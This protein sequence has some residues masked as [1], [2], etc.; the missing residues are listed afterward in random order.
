M[1]AR[2][3]LLT[4][5]LAA[6]RKHALA[7]HA[8][9][10]RSS[11]N[12]ILLPLPA[13]RVAGMSLLVQVA[14][15]RGRVLIRGHQ[16]AAN[17]RSLSLLEHGRPHSLLR[18]LPR[19]RSVDHL[20]LLQQNVVHAGRRVPGH[21]ARHAVRCVVSVHWHL[22]LVD[23]LVV[24]DDGHVPGHSAYLLLRMVEL[25]R[26]VRRSHPVVTLV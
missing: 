13:S 10:V 23:E 14:S 5:E 11:P 18:L 9:L 8:A 25:S 15:Y 2:G 21:A 24:P 1:S 16:L 6:G 19:G 3:Q 4:L 20:L 12:H 26:G 22:P 17:A 7:L